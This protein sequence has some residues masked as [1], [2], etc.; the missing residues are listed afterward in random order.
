[1]LEVII[2]NAVKYEME[3][4]PAPNSIAEK[5]WAAFMTNSST[6]QK[7]ISDDGIPSTTRSSSAHSSHMQN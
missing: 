2:P 4:S 1:M 6:S 7:M 3:N 5:R